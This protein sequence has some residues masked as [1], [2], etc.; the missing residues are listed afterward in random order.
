MLTAMQVPNPTSTSCESNRR[1][2]TLVQ[3][4]GRRLA[5]DTVPLNQRLE[6]VFSRLM[7]DTV[8]TPPTG[9]MQG[10]PGTRSDGS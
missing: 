3:A 10:I 6:F 4:R 7:A 2:P 1:I 9:G 8:G 5:F